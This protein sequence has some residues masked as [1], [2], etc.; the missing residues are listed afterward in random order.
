MALNP[1]RGEVG[2]ERARRAKKRIDPGSSETV[3]TVQGLLF[4]AWENKNMGAMKPPGMMR[5]KEK[6]R[7]RERKKKKKNTKKR[8]IKGAL[9]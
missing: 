2:Q 1:C 4:Q 9:L 5:G 3:K 8:T 7:K 6:K